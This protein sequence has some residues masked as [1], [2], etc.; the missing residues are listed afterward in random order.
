MKTVSWFSAGA[1]S[2]VATKLIIDEVDEI[3]YIHIDNQHP[4]SLRFVDECSEWFGREI[5]VLQSPYKTVANAIRG[6]G[7]RGYINGPGGAACTRLLKRR[8]RA[9]W[10]M[11]QEEKL[12]YVWGLDCG[13]KGRQDKI[14]FNM[15]DQEH[16]FPLA[17]KSVSKPRAHEILKASGIKRPVMYDLG[18]PNNNCIGCVKGG[19]GYWNKIRID[20]PEDFQAMAELERIVGASCING[21][22]LDELEPDRGRMSDIILDDCGI[23]CELEKL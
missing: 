2:A 10:E 1:S 5:T 12:C 7:G 15:P 16:R 20:F 14:I 6:A 21:V 4:D 13:E 17:E 22:Y 9:E 18:Y 3:I 8:V 23:F 11:D 19:M